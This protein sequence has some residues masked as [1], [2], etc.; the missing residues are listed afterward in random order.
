MKT[1]KTTSSEVCTT[2]E[3]AHIL[4]ISVSSVQQL[5]EA[6]IIEA[7][8]TKGGHRRIPL[9]AVHAYK[10]TPGSSADAAEHGRGNPAP[11]PGNG[12]TAVLVIEDSRLQRELY[13]GALASW[14]LPLDLVYCDNGYKALLEIARS[15]PDV[16]LADIVMEG[17]DGYEVVKTILNDPQLQDV[18]IAIVSSLDQDEMAQRGG[19][20]AGVVFFPKP[21]NFDELRGYLRACCARRE[22]ESR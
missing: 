1:A 9:A 4:G 5:V 18:S 6:G 2:Q 22:R 15:K 13:A 3:A 10:A 21:V 11:R 20:P 19:I 12:R 17:M 8:K 7:W 14:G 16:V